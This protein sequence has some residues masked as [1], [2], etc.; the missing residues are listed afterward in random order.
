M[1]RTQVHNSESRANHSA[2]N[3][4]RLLARLS[5]TSKR[6]RFRLAR[7]QAVSSNQL[8]SPHGLVLIISPSEGQV[9]QSLIVV[10]NCNPGSAHRQAA[11]LISSHN[12]AAGIVRA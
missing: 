4:A 9:F 12:S 2:S 5:A 10:W 7:L 1:S 6:T 11:K 8:Y 3:V